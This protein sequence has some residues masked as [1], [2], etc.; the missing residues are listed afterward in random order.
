MIFSM[1]KVL[2]SDQSQQNKKI[3][4]FVRKHTVRAIEKRKKRRESVGRGDRNGSG[5]TN[6]SL[7]SQQEQ[8]TWNSLDGHVQQHQ[9]QSA[10][11]SSTRTQS[12]RFGGMLARN[13]SIVSDTILEMDE[14]RVSGSRTPIKRSG[15]NSRRRA[16]PPSAQ[17]KAE[18]GFE[19]TRL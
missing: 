7:N 11:V 3:S 19:M 17:H 9:Q 1:F 5:A 2:Q 15:H 10:G 16:P 18:H 13:E 12:V 8:F 4:N 14:E 6:Q